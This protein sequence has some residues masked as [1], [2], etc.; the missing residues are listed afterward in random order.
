MNRGAL[1]GSFQS[2]VLLSEKITLPIPERLSF[3]DAATLP[4]AYSTAT[5]GLNLDLGIPLP[6][7]EATVPVET[8]VLI[9]GGGAAI[10][11]MCVQ[12]LKNAGFDNVIATASTTSHPLVQSLGASK[13]FDSRTPLEEL[14]ASIEK[15]AGGKVMY[16]Y[17]VISAEGTIELANRVVDP[18]GRRVVLCAFL[19][20]ILKIHS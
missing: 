1:I 13:V 11:Q 16:I 5:T 4:L 14:A 18:Q 10:G 20:W 7:V 17:D 15:E 12:L 8:P 9:L 19:T 3:A 6:G 2:K